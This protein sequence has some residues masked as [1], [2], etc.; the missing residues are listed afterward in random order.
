VQQKRSAPCSS[1]LPLAVRPLAQRVVRIIALLA[2]TAS[3]IKLLTTAPMQNNAAWIALLLPVDAAV[4]WVV[5][6]R[7]RS[8]KAVAK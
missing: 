2:A 4:G 1:P 3:L 8:R 5:L 7:G 6:T